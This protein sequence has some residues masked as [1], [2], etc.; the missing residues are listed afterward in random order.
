[1]AYRT[2]GR[3]GRKISIIPREHTEISG[4]SHP[5][6]WMYEKFLSSQIVRLLSHSV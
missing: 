6:A 1:V 2:V 4:I 3:M 5:I